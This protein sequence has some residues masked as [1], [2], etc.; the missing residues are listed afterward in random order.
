MII[1]TLKILSMY[2]VTASEKWEGSS[3]QLSGFFLFFFAIPLNVILELP[4]KQP[5]N[6]DCLYFPVSISRCALYECICISQRQEPCAARKLNGVS[7]VYSGAAVFLI[8]NVLSLFLDRRSVQLL[9]LLLSAVRLVLGRGHPPPLP[10]PR[11]R[12][13]I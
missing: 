10:P 6:M 5:S 1:K 3:A 2:F 11:L 7:V 9:Q 8:S 13:D 12:G 4:S